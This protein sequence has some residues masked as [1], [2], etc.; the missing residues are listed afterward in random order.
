MRV[1]WLAS[2]LVLTAVP[3]SAWADSGASASSSADTPHLACAPVKV[4]F[5]LN[6]DQLYDSE[7][8]LL[9]HYAQCL[10]NNQAQRI[11]IIG[12]A[13]ERGPSD[14]NMKLGQ[15]RADTVSRYLQE[16]GAQASQ[17]E[18][19]VSHGEDSPICRQSDLKCWQLNRRT[20]IRESCHL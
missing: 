16:K 2:L 6:S 18:A 15:R 17:I 13:D 3:I 8:P 14:Y 1:S 20:A 7:K 4:H 11:T 19:V 10:Q 9:D 5:A 12:N